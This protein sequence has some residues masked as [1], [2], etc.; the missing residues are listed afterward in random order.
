VLLLQQLLF[1]PDLGFGQAA[2]LDGERDLPAQAQQRGFILIQEGARRGVGQQHAGE[3]VL[4][5][6]CKQVVKSA[7]Q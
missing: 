5:A 2:A 6:Q 7:L 3:A 1:E 4:V